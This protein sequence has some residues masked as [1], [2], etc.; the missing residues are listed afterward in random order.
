MTIPLENG[1]DASMNDSSSARRENRSQFV[2]R[3]NLELC[4][5][6]VGWFLI[7]TPP[8][9]LRQMTETAPLHMFVCDLDDQLGA[10]RFPRKILIP[11]PAAL[12]A[13]HAM[14]AFT[15]SG[16]VLGPTFPGMIDKRLSTIGFEKFDKLLTRLVCEASAHTHVLQ[17][18]M[19]VVKTKQQGSHSR[20]LTF[21]VPSKTGDD[22]I[23]VPLMLD[24]QHD[25]LVRFV[26]SGNQ[27][28]HHS[29]EARA[30][31]PAKPVGRHAQFGGRRC[32]MNRRRCG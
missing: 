17:G 8:A 22:A 20:S 27:L 1:A 24:L 31:E 14:V 25:A 3:N 7:R 23:A 15:V 28:S 5:S 13:R 2:W 29:I 11:T 9:K 12:T 26:S 30:L 4:V 21:F 6:A 19:L 10:K 18:A 32:H 16:C